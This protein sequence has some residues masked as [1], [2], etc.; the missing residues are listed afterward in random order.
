M[1]SVDTRRSFLRGAT[2]AT[3]GLLAAAGTQAAPGQEPST[4]PKVGH[5][6]ADHKSH[7]GGAPGYPRDQPGPGGPVGSP[8]DRGKLVPGVRGAD[9]PPVPVEAPDLTKLSWEMKDGVKEFHL[10]AQPVQRELLPG[11]VMNH[12]G[13]NGAMPGP[14]IEVNEGDRVRIVVH[15]ELPEPTTLHLHGIELPIAMDGV[16]FVAQNPIMPGETGVYDITLHQNGTFFYHPHMAM[17]EAFGMVGLFIIHPKEA[18]QPVVDQDFALITQEF[19]ID[20]A[21]NTAASARM[22]FNWFTVNGRSGPYGTPLVVRLGNRVRIRI[23]NFSTDDHH[24][25]HLHGHTFWVTGNEGGRIPESAWVP[26][27]NVLVGVA[28]VREIEFIANNPGDWVVHCHMF[29]HMMNHMVPGIGPGSRKKVMEGQMASGD[30]RAGHGKMGHQMPMDSRIPTDPYE[31]PGYPQDSGM[32]AMMSEEQIEKLVSNPLTRGMAPQW[33]MGVMGLMTVV[34]VLPPD[35]YE[36]VISGRG[37]IPAGASVPGTKFAPA[38]HMG[39]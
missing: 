31:V 3:A 2:L 5:D 7:R 8:T 18:Y 23:L 10:Y 30:G 29:H 6:P 15:N 17:Q 32:H 38:G 9:E 35:L 24:P 34:R 36:K 27:N 26:G 14:T 16:E 20:P 22:D 11:E 28:Q 19:V 25:M 1:D 37:E 21:V 39:H 13:Y 33:Y 12:W 4:G